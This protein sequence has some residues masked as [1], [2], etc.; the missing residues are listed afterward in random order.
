MEFFFL[1]AIAVVAL[2]VA[3]RSFNQAAALRTRIEA[4]ETAA[5]TMTAAPG[6]TPP[7]LP[8]QEPPRAAPAAAENVST[9][10]EAAPPIAPEPIPR[11]GPAI[12]LE[13]EQATGLPP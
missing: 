6:A 13:V 8:R 9:T 3:I 7:P 2:I 10:T 5:R 11:V 4:L 12:A 1:F